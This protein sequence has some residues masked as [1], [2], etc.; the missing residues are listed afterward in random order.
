MQQLATSIKSGYEVILFDSDLEHIYKQAIGIVLAFNNKDH[1]VPTRYISHIE[2]N[3]FQLR[4]IGHLSKE[5]LDLSDSVVK[6]KLSKKVNNSLEKLQESLRD[7]LNVTNAEEA[8]TP[9]PTNVPP[10]GPLLPDVVSPPPGE[11][12]LP[13]PTPVS[14]M[15]KN[16]QM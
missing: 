16:I 4:N 14:K 8:V 15:K 12:D 13:P 9:A 11:E 2:F 10:K 5:I 6:P 7:F 1:Y 3:K